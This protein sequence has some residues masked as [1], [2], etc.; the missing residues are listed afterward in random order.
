MCTFDINFDIIFFLF[1]I[2]EGQKVVHASLV[3]GSTCDECGWGKSKK[4]K[5]EKHGREVA[6]VNVM[7]KKV[8]SYAL[9]I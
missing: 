7:E 5:E 2:E 9:H 1:K 8:W 4:K 3:L 6:K